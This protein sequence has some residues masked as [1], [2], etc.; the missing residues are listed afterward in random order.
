MMLQKFWAAALWQFTHIEAGL[1]YTANRHVDPSL[2][3]NR[4]KSV[5]VRLDNQKKTKVDVDTIQFLKYSKGT[6]NSNRFKYV[7]WFQQ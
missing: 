1:C 7:A 4:A 6:S 2:N 3:P 5:E